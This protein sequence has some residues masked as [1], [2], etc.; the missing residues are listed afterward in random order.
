MSRGTLATLGSLGRALLLALLLAGCTDD[1]KD[2][3]FVVEGT[4]HDSGLGCWVVSTADTN[5]EIHDGMPAEYLK[6]GTSVRATVRVIHM[7]SICMVGP[8]VE[9]LE[10]TRTG[11]G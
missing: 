11:A 10:V 5:Y 3:S 1:S 6:E 9:V 2:D 4:I 8:M 7:P